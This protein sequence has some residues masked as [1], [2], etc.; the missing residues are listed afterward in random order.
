MSQKSPRPLAD[1]Q[2][3][4]GEVI[5]EV[6]LSQRHRLT[7]RAFMAVVVLVAHRSADDPKTLLEADAFRDAD[8]AHAITSIVEAAIAHRHRLTD[9]AVDARG[10][11]F[12]G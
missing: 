3:E 1:A 5:A 2:R 12:H 4:L 11:V 8:V 6:V 7:P 9:I 10:E